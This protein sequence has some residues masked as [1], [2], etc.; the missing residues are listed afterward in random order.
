MKLPTNY[1]LKNLKI[2]IHLN[3]FKQMRSDITVMYQE[4]VFKNHIWYIYI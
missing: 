3:V 4:N 1:S 2:Y